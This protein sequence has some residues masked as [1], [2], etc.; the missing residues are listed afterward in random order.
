MLRIW[1]YNEIIM[2]PLTIS[3]KSLPKDDLVII[4]QKEYEKFL[5]LRRWKKELDEDIKESLE[6]VKRGE[7]F[8]PFRSGKE[9]IESLKK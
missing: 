9:L 1:R 2:T 3:K 6:Q 8:G 5:T 7:V 4:A